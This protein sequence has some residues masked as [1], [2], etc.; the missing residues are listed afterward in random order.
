MFR[1][2]ALQRESENERLCTIV[3]IPR[4]EVRGYVQVQP[5]RSAIENFPNPTNGSWWIVQVQPTIT[6]LTLFARQRAG[7]VFRKLI[8]GCTET[9]ET[10][11]IPS[12]ARARYSS[13][14]PFRRLDLNNPPTAV[15]GIRILFTPRFLVGRI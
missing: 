8:V 15:G 10:L 7:G 5:T 9:L 3:G 14:G 1:M 11:A 6:R 4:T 12:D 2:E 13:H